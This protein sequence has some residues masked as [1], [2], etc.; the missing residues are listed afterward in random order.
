MTY[1]PPPV[2]PRD[3][4]RSLRIVL[5]VVGVVVAVCCLGGAAGG[6]FLF[7]TVQDAVGPARS[8]TSEYLNAVRDG[9]H[10]RAYDLL[11]Q[12]QRDQVTPDDFARQRQAQPR[13][14]DYDITGM[15]VSTDNGRT[16]GVASVRLE[17]AS[18]ETAESISLLREN[19]EW[20]VCP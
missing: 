13:L 18:G 11:C 9:D 16:T 6:F 15:R 3:N 19:D 12:R 5:I 4:R 17:T 10:Q 2:P 8:A 20:R 14:V 1:H 7:R